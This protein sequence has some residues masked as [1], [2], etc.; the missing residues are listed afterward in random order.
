MESA[1]YALLEKLIGEKLS[2]E[3]QIEYWEDP[4]LSEVI[5]R[6]GSLP[7]DTVIFDLAFLVVLERCTAIRLGPDRP[8]VAFPGAG[9]PEAVPAIRNHHGDRPGDRAGQ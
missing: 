4:R 7:A 9:K 8:G 5:G 3:L 6:A 1:A 2:G